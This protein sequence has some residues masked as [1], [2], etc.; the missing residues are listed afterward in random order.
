M[1]LLP[2]FQVLENF[3]QGLWVLKPPH[4]TARAAGKSTARAAGK[5]TRFKDD[6][7]SL[8]RIFERTGSQNLEKGTEGKDPTEGKDQSIYAR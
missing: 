4:P 2:D 6:F 3:V 1:F 5:S 8:W 7:S